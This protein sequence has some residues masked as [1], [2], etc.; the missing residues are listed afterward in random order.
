MSAALGLAFDGRCHALLVCA[1][2]HRIAPNAPNP[3]AECEK[4]SGH[5]SG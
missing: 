3:A 2:G 4:V 1:L 5:S